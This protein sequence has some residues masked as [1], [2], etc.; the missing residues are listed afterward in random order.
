M[1]RHVFSEL[2]KTRD[3]TKVDRNMYALIFLFSHYH[4]SPPN[5]EAIL[6]CLPYH[7]VKITKLKKWV[8]LKFVKITAHRRLESIAHIA[9]LHFYLNL[10][11]IILEKLK[12]FY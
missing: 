5:R 12:S 3:L 11:L 4:L 10:S 6:F 9:I 8:I 7:K 1:R 2:S